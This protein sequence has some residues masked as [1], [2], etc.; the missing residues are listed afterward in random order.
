[1]NK[2]I[3]KDER[4]SWSP[5]DYGG[6]EEITLEGNKI[7]LPDIVLQNGYFNF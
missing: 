4:I 1:M 7:W 5:K 2:K 3:W 6:I